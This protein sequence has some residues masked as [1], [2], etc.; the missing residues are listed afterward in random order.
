MPSTTNYNPGDVILIPFPYT[1]LSTFK[2]RPCLIISS[3][4][5]NS[6]HPDIIAVAITSQVP[7]KP[8]VSEYRLSPKEQLACGLPKPSIIKLGKI[9]TL[10]QRLIRKTLGNLQHASTKRVINKL[11]KIFKI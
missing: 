6:S 8:S 3:A 1:D 4:A 9:V 5:F 7:E 2:Q 10:D 11:Q